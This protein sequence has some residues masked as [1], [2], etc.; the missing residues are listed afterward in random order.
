MRYFKATD[1]TALTRIQVEDLKNKF[2]KEL[3]RQA[4]AAA[5][6][7]K[8][9]ITKT[10]TI[11]KE[12]NGKAAKPHVSHNQKKVQPAATRVE[13][14][15]STR[16]R[17]EA[18][19][20]HPNRETGPAN[21]SAKSD[22]KNKKKKK[23]SALAN[24]SNPHHLRN[25]VP[26]RLPNSGP[27]ATALAAR[28]AQNLI[29]PLPVRFLC[30]DLPLYD[31]NGRGVPQSKASHNNT[32]EEWICSFCEYDLFYGWDA[33]FRDAIRSRKKALRR[34]RRAQEKAARAT[35][36]LASRSAVAPSGYAEEDETDEAE[37]DDDDDDRRDGGCAPTHDA[38]ARAGFNK[39]RGAEGG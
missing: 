4:S 15:H 26:S 17:A 29:S 13:E 19:K 34:R 35:S 18:A 11:M 24:A 22:N 32:A 8:N 31:K 10:T 20:S 30:A 12:G 39:G 1:R 14:Q 21:N 38:P 27:T 7:T 3:L 25:Y 2:E 6:A 36:G 28:A 23:R 33:S 16:I 37:Y 5:K 9:A